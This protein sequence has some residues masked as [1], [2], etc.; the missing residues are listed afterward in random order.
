MLARIQS[1]LLQGIEA[2]PCEIE[3]DLDQ[4]C[5]DK[6]DIVGL[7]D[8]AVKEAIDRVRSAVGNAGYPWPSGKLLVNLAP[9]DVRKEG[10]LY[11]LP[12]AVGMLVASGVIDERAARPVAVPAGGGGEG[13]DQILAE[14]M[15]FRRFIFA[16][17][18]ALDGRI[19][20][21]RGAIAMASLAR[22]LGM[23]GVVLPAENASEAAVVDGIDVIGVR[24]L[25]EVVGH[26]NGAL[27][28]EPHPPIDLKALIE[29]TQ[30][31]VDF[32]DVKGQETVKRAMTIAAAGAHNI[33]G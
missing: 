28:T 8:I 13:E 7:P 3:I 31:E 20:P 33:L 9:A 1:Y 23:R 32:A 12:I 24:T 25:S 5:M 4:R 26:L 21:V 17:E 30:A 6:V 16:G 15:D 29:H 19:R 18:L 10:P 22:S 2:S 11:D 27:P 14:G